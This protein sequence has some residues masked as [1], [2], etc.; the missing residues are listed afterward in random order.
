MR[1]VLRVPAVN[2]TNQSFLLVYCEPQFLRKFDS[3]CETRGKIRVKF[4]ILVNTQADSPVT[5]TAGFFVH[6]TLRLKTVDVMFPAS[7]APF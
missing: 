3:F 1:F 2:P 7:E 6:V 5:N 4:F